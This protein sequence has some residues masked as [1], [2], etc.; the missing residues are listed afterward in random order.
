MTLIL[1]VIRAPTS[2]A[3]HRISSNDSQAREPGEQRKRCYERE[4]VPLEAP[5]VARSLYK[6]HTPSAVSRFFFSFL[7]FPLR[8]PQLACCHPPARSRLCV[9]DHVDDDHYCTRPSTNKHDQAPAASSPHSTLPASKVRVPGDRPTGY[10]PHRGTVG[11]GGM[12]PPDPDTRTPS[13]T[14]EPEKKDP[15]ARHR[16]S[17]G[18]QNLRVA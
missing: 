9:S 5:T 16:P 7:G 8:H 17:P 15:T 2:C 6:P 12:M 4:L 10:R 1:L 13:P 3:L 18:G 14:E 11:Y